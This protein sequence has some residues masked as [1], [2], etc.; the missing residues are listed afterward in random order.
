MAWFHFLTLYKTFLQEYLPY[1]LE[2]KLP[3]AEKAELLQALNAYPQKTS[4]YIDLT[5]NC[6]L[7]TNSQM[8]SWK[9]F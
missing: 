5:P 2:S 1:G 8:I 7:I 6:D 3:Q 9:E 4:P